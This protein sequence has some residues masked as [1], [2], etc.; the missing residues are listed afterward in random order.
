MIHNDVASASPRERFPMREE[1]VVRHSAASRRFVQATLLIT[2]AVVVTP[3]AALAQRRQFGAKAGP[4]FMGI[5]LAKDDGQ[6]YRPRIA[7]YVSGFF[8][9]PLNPRFGMQFEAVSSPKGTRLKEPPGVTQ[10]LLLQYFEMPVLLRVAGPTAGSAPIYFVGGP[11]FGFKVSAKEQLSTLAG[12]VIAGA[13]QDAGH[14]VKPFESG[15]IGGA[16]IE[17]GKYMLVEGR[18]SYGLTNVNNVDGLTK[19]TNHGLSFTIGVRF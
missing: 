11:F 13:R 10:T 15:L 17:L 1:L 16:G 5:T 3:S 2:I 14:L 19:F 12:T 9:L 18:Y 7:P 8:M 4:A 6:N